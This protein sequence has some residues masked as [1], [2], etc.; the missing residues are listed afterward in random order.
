MNNKY[1]L[2]KQKIEDLKSE[3]E[4]HNNL[5]YNEDKNEIS[6]LEFD[7]KLRYLIELE[8]KYPE[9]KTSDSPSERVGGKI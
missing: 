5:Y 3:I 9:F 8:K 7:K 1:Q 4:Y 6:D 2:V